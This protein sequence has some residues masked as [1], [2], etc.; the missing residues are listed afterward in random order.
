MIECRSNAGSAYFS[1]KNYHSIVFLVVCD[2]KYYFTFLDIGD[3]G[4]TNGASVQSNSAFWQVFKYPTKLKL[5][6]PASHRNKI[7]PHVLLGDDIFSLK[8]WLMKPYQ[9]RV[10]KSDQ[11]AT[12]STQTPIKNAFGILSA[13]WRIFR[14]PI[15]ENLDLPVVQ[16]ITQA[17]VCLRN[18]LCFTENAS[19]F[20]TGVVDCEDNR[21]NLFLVTGEILPMEMKRH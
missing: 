11:L 17:T 12:I 5:P 9:G 19:Y 15:R 16:R 6:S 18:Y 13:K 21:S 4:G 14:R 1:Y 2:A 3:Y 7:L 20:P 10:P 8:P